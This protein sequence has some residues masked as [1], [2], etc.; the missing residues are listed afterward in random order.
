[1]ITRMDCTDILEQLRPHGLEHWRT[2]CFDLLDHTA[3]LE[4]YLADPTEHPLPSLRQA[5]LNATRHPHRAD[6]TL[7]AHLASLPLFEY[8]VSDKSHRH[9]WHPLTE[10]FSAFS[11]RH[12]SVLWVWRDWR[13][14]PS[15]AEVAIWLRRRLPAPSLVL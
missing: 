6:E 4:T 3:G 12:F 2:V 10:T 7:I 1:M 5:I 13:P 15:P 11:T 9:L 8:R 14:Y